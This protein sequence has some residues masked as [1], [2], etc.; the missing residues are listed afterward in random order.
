MKPEIV[1]GLEGAAWPA[2]LLNANCVVLRANTAAMD[3]FGEALAGEMPQLLAIWS[4][5]N[6]GMPEGFFARWEKSPITAADLK[7]RVAEGH[8][9]V[10][11]A[12]IARRW[13]VNGRCIARRRRRRA[14]T[15]SSSPGV[16]AG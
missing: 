11:F 10:R 14:R 13:R 4:P 12:I 3:V 1:F 16:R 9:M 8:T 7:F 15:G 5:E 2:L 6:G